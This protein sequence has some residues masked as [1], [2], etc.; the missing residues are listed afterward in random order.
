MNTRLKEY[1]INFIGLKIGEHQFDYELNK[2][3]F[4]NFEYQDFEEVEL[5]ASLILTKKENAL[6]LNFSISGKVKV[7]CDI[8]NEPFWLTI[9]TNAKVQVKF[10]NEF[11][12]TN[13]EILII[14]DGE[15]KLNVSQYLYELPVLAK[16]L[17]LI[18]PD[19]KSGKRGQRALKNLERLSPGSEKETSKEN[20]PRWDKLKE[21]LN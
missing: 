7:L 9:N 5:K 19:V 15:H 16:P 6:G 10:G 20:D 2:E 8:I 4:T 14:P 21:L 3:F 17:K 13:E 11:D 18:H 1:E 12:D